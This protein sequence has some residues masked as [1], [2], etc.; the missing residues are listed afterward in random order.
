MGITKI[1]LVENCYGIS[2]KVYIGKTK[3][4]RY[5]AHKKQFGDQIYY[6]YIDKIN[7]LD[8]KDWEPLETYWIEQFRQWDFDIQNKNKGGG[9]PVSHS[10]IIK[11]QMSIKRKGKNFNQ[12]WRNKI[13]QSKKGCKIW[14]EGL[15]FSEE[16]KYKISQSKKGIST[17]SSSYINNKNNIKPIYQYDKN[18]NFIREWS[19]AIEAAKFYGVN[20]NSIRHCCNNKTKTSCGFVWKDKN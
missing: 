3:T 5:R 2:N 17:P 4:T 7:S 14:S 12:S 11:A 18:M 6:C 10:N 15:T 13:S 19:S 9:G 8:K 16:H 20:S 1:Y